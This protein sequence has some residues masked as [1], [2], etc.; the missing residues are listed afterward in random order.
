MGG[1]RFDPAA[2]TAP[3]DPGGDGA[4]DEY[5]LDGVA[6]PGGQD[7]LHPSRGRFLLR[8]LSEGLAG[9]GVPLREPR[10]ST[11]L[12]DGE[13]GDIPT[14]VFWA[15]KYH[16]HVH[17]GSREAE[18]V[19]AI[20]GQADNTVYVIDD[21]P[22]RCMIGRVVGTGTDGC[23]YCLVAGVDIGTYW[24]FARDED[25]V[26]DAFVDTRHLLLCAVYAQPEG[27]S[28]VVEVAHYRRFRDVPADYLPGSP[29]IEF[30]DTE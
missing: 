29:P 15:M 26:A 17:F 2:R 14:A 8:P 18:A 25:P 7:L 28:N 1:D 23:T 3:G 22:D 10:R 16:R 12:D 6:F 11:P 24:R 19:R 30:S 13:E 5:S 4:G 20:L 21:G 9:M 27:V